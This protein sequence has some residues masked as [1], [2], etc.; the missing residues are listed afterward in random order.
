MSAPLDI[1]VEGVGF[2]ASRLPGWDV[3]RAVLRGESTAP[4]AAAARPLPSLLPPAERR[5]APDTVAVALEVAARACVNAG[6]D[7]KSLASVFASANGD[8]PVS[9]AIC[10]TLAKNP[11]L[12][13]PTKFHNSV[14][15]AA[16]GYWT[17]ATGCMQPYTAICARDCTFAQ[18]LLESVAQALTEAAPVLLVAYDI[19]SR[20]PAATM[21]P[22]RGVLAGALVLSPEPRERN[23]ARLTLEV[24]E[25]AN[26]RPSE[27]RAENS[28]LVAG[29]AMAGALPLFEALADGKEREIAQRLAPRMTLSIRVSPFETAA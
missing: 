26:P 9:D 25:D 28:A 3:A 22:S 5:R 16:A 2:W 1:F 21:Q 19:E 23:L 8:L 18:G 13:S 15:N 12:T 29:N 7:P 17:I 11:A 20:G 4:P 27:A 14:H 24:R 10:E 6:R